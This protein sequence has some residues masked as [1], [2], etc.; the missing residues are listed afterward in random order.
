MRVFVTGASGWIGSAVVTEL[1]GAGHEVLGLARSDTSAAAVTAL[2]AQVHRGDLDDVESLRAGAAE[3]DG[4]AHLG[5]HHDFS[6]MAEA[7]ELD[8]HAI[9]TFGDV[10]AGSDGPLVVASGAL[11]LTTDGVAT[12]RDAPDASLHPRIA[13]A[14]TVLALADRGVRSAVVRFAPT[15]HGPGD[16]GFVATLV[17]LARRTG[18]AAYI[19][20]GANRWPAVNRADAAVLVR[21]AVESAP[22]GSVLHAVDEQGIPT[23]EIAEAIGRATGVPTRSIPADEAA[24]HFGWIGGFFAMDAAVSNAATRE[25]L[26]WTPSHPGLL[27]DIEAGAYSDARPHASAG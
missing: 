20:D 22:A 21:L 23:R 11:G 1:I 7:A 18:V 5:Y 17:E 15:V 8:R 10:L 19:G 9:E 4:V 16:H 25:L 24:A 2:G 3:A 26:G 12:E 6:Q 27:A 13:N 14:Q